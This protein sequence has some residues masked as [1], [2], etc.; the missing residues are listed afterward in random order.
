MKEFLESKYMPNNEKKMETVE[1]NFQK[2]KF[3]EKLCLKELREKFDK[4]ETYLVGGAVRDFILKRE[5]K[6]FDF[7][8]RGIK[9]EDLEKFLSEFGQVNLVGKTFG[10]FKFVP[11]N[12]IF[13]PIDFALPRKEHAFGTGGY[14]DFK[15][16]SDANLS[17][18]DDLSRRDF[19]L[20]AMALKL[21][22]EGKYELV[23]PFGGKKDIEKKIIRAV[24]KPEERFKEDYSRMLRALRFACQLDFS[25]EDKTWR[26]ILKNIFHLNDIRREVE[27]V[28]E[29]VYVEPEI[30]ESRV[31]PYEVIAK[32]LL[33]SF[34]YHPVKSLDLYEQ[35]GAF[36]ELIPEI[37]K[38]KNCPQPENFHSE[39]DVWIHT[40]LA[41]KK[42]FSPEFKKQF[43]DESPSIEL[44]MAVL[45]HDIGKPETIKTPEKDGTE[46]IRFDEH[47]IV[48]AKIVKRICEKLKLS[49]P[50]NLGVDSERVAWLVQH[51]MLLVQGDISKMKPSTI[52]KY[53]FNSNVP[54]ENLL[55]LAFV[56]IS[57]TVPPDG[58]PDFSSFNQMTE[59][60]EQFKNLSATK[61]EL[62]R[63]L[64]NGHEVMKE[65]GLKPG[66]KIGELLTALREEQLEGRIKDRDEA[67][68]FLKK[69]L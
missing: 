20:N 44:I 25:I 61:K 62:P 12:W 16:Q 26:A 43:G 35:S 34:Y 54:G 46:R 66:P 64:L 15:V 24:G 21:F 39:G 28:G 32:E 45:F 67:I 30:L 56:D 19:T 55:K 29:A 22:D 4:A 1:A 42:L 63:P 41:L 38:L 17:I 36:K 60:I 5:I 50:E 37:L 52:E 69:Y 58:R 13:E 7:V 23:D 59:R 3:L 10:I 48:G 33:K 40:R 53:F 68:E 27:M 14:R 49:S 47:D 51:H 9:G 2:L 18:R 11:K 57:A 6:D 65:F 31:V 8:I